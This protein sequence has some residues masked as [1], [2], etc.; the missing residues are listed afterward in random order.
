MRLTL[1]QL[2]RIIREAIEDEFAPRRGG[3]SLPPA[4]PPEPEPNLFIFGPPP[5]TDN[6]PVPPKFPGT[7]LYQTT[8]T[9]RKHLTDRYRFT[10]TN[11]VT[12]DVTRG[13]RTV[14]SNPH[15][16][17]WHWHPNKPRKLTNE[18][19]EFAKSKGIKVFIDDNDPQFIKNTKARISKTA[20][21]R[22][23]MLGQWSLTPAF[24]DSAPQR[25]VPTPVQA[26]QPRTRPAPADKPA[27]AP[28]PPRPSRISEPT[29]TRN[30]RRSR[31]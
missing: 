8:D 17:R 4:P 15:T 11:K 29:V 27:A 31:I 13:V 26:P 18:E 23:Y 19:F 1:G 14:D 16:D 22:W 12:G 7:Y 10:N 21:G 9:T 30:S 28:K 25:T 24:R 2:K 20:D 5:E 3:G 6:N